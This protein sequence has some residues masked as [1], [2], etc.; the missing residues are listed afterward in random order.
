MPRFD[1]EDFERLRNEAIDRLTKTL[2]GGNDE[3]L[4]KWALQLDLYRNHPYGHVDTGTVAGLKA[5]TVDDVKMFFKN[6][7]HRKKLHIGVGGGLDAG[8]IDFVRAQLGTI[9][10]GPEAI[11]S[12]PPPVK[13]AGL[14]VTIIEKPCASTAISLGFPLDVTRAND[15]FYP[16]ALANSALGEHRTFNGRLMRDLRE[17]RGLNYG[18]YSYIE[19]FI[20]E[21]GSTFALTNNPRRQQYFSIWLRPVP[22]DKAAFALRAALWE[23]DRLVKN[24]LTADEF[25]A[26]RTF[27]RNYSKLWPQTVARRLGYAVDGALLGRDDLVTEL[28]RRLPRITRDQVQ[29]A[30]RRHLAS[31]G[32]RVAIVTQDAAGLRKILE[33][34]TPSPLVYDTQGTPPEILAEDAVIA[35]FPLRD[36]KVRVV[37]VGEMFEK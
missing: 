18:S 11:P 3:E 27:L 29:A 15:D 30:I 34:N 28:D 17:K 7:Y 26:T 37:P 22:H 25:E 2:R 12:L 21:G 33:S 4:A 35:K 1:P 16:L 31:P 24:G 36:V 19:D 20:Q 9:D 8:T 10:A 32:I 13:P 14:E 6:H 5:I 23:L